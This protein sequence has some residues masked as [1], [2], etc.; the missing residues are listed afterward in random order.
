MPT[1]EERPNKTH[2]FSRAIWEFIFYGPDFAT[3]D[4]TASK[5]H[6]DRNENFA[7]ILDVMRDLQRQNA[8]LQ[9]KML[10]IQNEFTLERNRR[11][12]EMIRVSQDKQHAGTQFRGYSES[13]E[14]SAPE[15]ATSAEDKRRVWSGVG[16]G[17]RS[18]TTQSPVIEL[19]D[20]MLSAEKDVIEDAERERKENDP[21]LK[22]LK[23]LHDKVE[24]DEYDGI[25]GSSDEEV[26]TKTEDRDSQATEGL[27]VE[28]DDSRRNE[29]LDIDHDN[30]VIVV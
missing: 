7:A 27:R 2:D 3:D 20:I 25:G 29:L 15:E 30:N 12:R 9:N 13:I 19:R 26:E 14:E 5:E 8:I 22:E 1:L 10:E 17:Q 24:V 4:A 16:L 11:S 21:E 23:E 18:A 6:G 28:V